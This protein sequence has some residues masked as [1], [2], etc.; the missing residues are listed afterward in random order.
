M[1]WHGALSADRAR[2]MRPRCLAV[3]AVLLLLPLLLLLLVRRQV[4][5]G[6]DCR[7]HRL[8]GRLHTV[9]SWPPPQPVPT[10]ANVSRLMDWF[11]TALCCDG[12]CWSRLSLVGAGTCG[13]EIPDARRL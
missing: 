7:A 11:C 1:A 10:L 12:C 3:S 5:S 13:M 8:P 2:W 9:P 4:A 6:A